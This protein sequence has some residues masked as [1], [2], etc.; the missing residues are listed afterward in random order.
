VTFFLE[1]FGDVFLE[2]AS[3]VI[4]SWSSWDTVFSD[5][6]GDVFVLSS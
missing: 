1:Q 3:C 4:F 5:Q 6:L 2:A